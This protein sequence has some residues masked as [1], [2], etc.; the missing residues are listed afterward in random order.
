MLVEYISYTMMKLTKIEP[1][2]AKFPTQSPGR[3]CVLVSKKK[4]K[5]AKINHVSRVYKSYNDET[6]QNGAQKCEIS[7]PKP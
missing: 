2:K 6:H 4:G 7:N 3:K 5:K 1:K